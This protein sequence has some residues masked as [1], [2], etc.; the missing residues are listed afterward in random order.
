[1]ALLALLWQALV[2][3]D[4]NKSQESVLW[5]AL[6]A[7][8]ENKSQESVQEMAAQINTL[9]QQCSEV[10]PYDITAFLRFWNQE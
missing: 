7:L 9:A 8:D 6:V 5:Q 4:E 1:M 10:P 2:A 3:L